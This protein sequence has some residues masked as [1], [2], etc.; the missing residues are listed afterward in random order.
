MKQLLCTDCNRC[1]LL[2]ADGGVVSWLHLKALLSEHNLL[3][4]QECPLFFFNALKICKMI[5]LTQWI[6]TTGLFLFQWTKGLPIIMT[7][8]LNWFPGPSSFVQ[9]IDFPANKLLEYGKKAGLDHKRHPSLSYVSVCW[10]ISNLY[11]LYFFQVPFWE[12]FCGY[13][14]LLLL[15]LLG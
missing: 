7:E 4:F 14:L 5:D 2:E 3:R 10:T 13:C 11:S 15:S 8:V 1:K 12:C 6:T 9:G